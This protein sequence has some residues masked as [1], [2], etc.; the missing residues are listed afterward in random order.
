MGLR[1]VAPLFV[2]RRWTVEGSHFGISSDNTVQSMFGKET[3]VPVGIWEVFIW[4]GLNTGT[5][6]HTV[7]IGVGG[8]A[9]WTAN[10]C[11]FESSF[12]NKASN[13]TPTAPTNKW[14]LSM[15]N[16]TPLVI[17]AASTTASKFLVVRAIIPVTTAGT[18]IPQLQFSAAPTGTNQVT[19]GSY[20]EVRPSKLVGVWA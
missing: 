14:N 3:A 18:L 7:A 8:T 10:T 1:G 17:S 2:P 19:R 12:Q 15:T 20:V 9:A 13:N 16:G 4:A 6:S 5:T 11:T